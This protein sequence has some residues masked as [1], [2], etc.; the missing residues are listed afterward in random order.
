MTENE[1]TNKKILVDRL[2]SDIISLED[3]LESARLQLV[4]LSDQ[5]IMTEKAIKNSNKDF[6]KQR[7]SQ[8]QLCDGIEKEMTDLG[9]TLLVLKASVNDLKIRIELSL[10]H[11]CRC[12]RAI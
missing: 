2:Q 11:I 5:K 8:E 6:Q 7:L 1:L 12:R 4:T 10:I 9:N 3:K